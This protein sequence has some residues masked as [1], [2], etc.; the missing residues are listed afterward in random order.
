MMNYLE[1][2][3][4]TVWGEYSNG[5]DLVYRLLNDRDQSW[6][7]QSNSSV[8]RWACPGGNGY[9]AAAKAHLSDDDKKFLSDREQA[10]RNALFC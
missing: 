2:K 4:Q 5:V 6:M 3:P 7:T 1:F 10:F 8:C 9:F